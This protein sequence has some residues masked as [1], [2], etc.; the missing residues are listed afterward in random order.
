MIYIWHPGDI[1][2]RHGIKSVTD[3]SRDRELLADSGGGEG[4]ISLTAKMKATS[5]NVVRPERV[6]SVW[7]R[8]RLRISG[9]APMEI[10]CAPYPKETYL[11]RLMEVHAVK[12]GPI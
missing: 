6:A 2:G 9:R 3:F 4:I 8:V 12:G 1:R 10:G 5:L 7:G 11:P